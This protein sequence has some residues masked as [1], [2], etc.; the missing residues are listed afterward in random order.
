MLWPTPAD[1]AQAVGGYPDVCLLDSKLKEGKPKETSANQLLIYTG[2]FSTV[3]PIEAAHNDYA[4]RCWNK[5][6]GDSKNRYEKIDDYLKQ[7]HLPYFVDFEYVLEGILINGKKWPITRMEW[8]K[9]E[10]LRDFIEHNLHDPKILSVAAGEFRKM[11]ETLHANQISHGDLQS[12]NIM[13]RK[14][15]T[16]ITIKLIDYDSLFVP[17]LHGQKSPTPGLP[18]YQHPSRV[19]KCD[20]K[21]DYFSELVI[22]LSFLSLSEKPELWNQ[23]KGKTEKGLLFSK[24]DFEKPYQSDIFKELNSLPPEIQQLTITLKDYCIQTSI[25]QLQPLEVILPKFGPKIHIDYGFTLL[26]DK[27]YDAALSEFQKAIVIAYYGIGLV[28]LHSHRYSDAIEAFSK[29]ISVEPTYKEAYYGLGLSYHKSGDNIKTIAAL[30]EALKIDPHYLLAKQLLDTIKSTKLGSRTQWGLPEGAKA[31]LGKGKINEIAFSPDGTCLAVA[32][33]IGTWLYDART[34]QE[35]KLLVGHTGSVRSVCYSPDGKTIATGSSDKTVRL[36]D[37]DTGQHL[38]TLTGHTRSVNSVC[39]SPDGETIATASGGIFAINEGDNTVRLWDVDTRELLQTLIG[40]KSWVNSVCY[41]P[42]GETIATAS[43]DSTVRLWD[44]DTGKLLQTFIGHKMGVRSVCYSPDGETIAT[45]SWDST[46]RLWEADTGKYLRTL[47]GHTNSVRS[48]CYS[49]DGETIATAS[50]DKTMCLWEADTGKLLQTLTG[51]TNSVESVCYSPDGETIATASSDSTVRLWEADTGKLLQTLTGHTD[52]VES[53]CYSPNGE[54]IATANEDKTV[55]LWEADT[56][57][58][59]QILI[60]HTDSVRSVCYSPD[61]RTIATGSSDKTVRLWE[62]DT[63]QPL[64]TFTRHT[65]SVRSVCYSPDGRT[66]ATGSSDK[67]VRLWDVD[68]TYP[69]FCMRYV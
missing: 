19:D 11:F 59:L 44:V 56:G 49:P 18:E 15:G 45:G 1:Y 22:Y 20:K 2:G 29:A 60:G 53:M 39:Y 41:S 8:A 31:R 43:S 55:R 68:L 28:H 7:V 14:N 37:V 61:G 16:D 40:H 69:H 48:V 12:G 4:L 62:A 63:E 42:D 24:D 6:I 17:A 50:S 46:V 38:Q 51:H 10:S 57:K 67:T 30:N 54:M 13:L 52:S 5:D 23:F 66:I 64:R 3:F 27:R 25:D 21:M 33:S 58:L 26:N 34:M 35:Q 32:S 65:D 36:W 9:G 47:T